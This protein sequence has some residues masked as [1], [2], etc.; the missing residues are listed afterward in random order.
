MKMMLLRRCRVPLLLAALGAC[1]PG[2]PPAAATPDAARPNVL[3]LLTDD[4]GY[5]EL[6]CH[7]NPVLRTPNLDRLHDESLRFTDFHAAPMCTPT[8]GQLMTGLD[9]LRNGAMNVS[10][11][12]T[13]LRRD[14]PTLPRLFAD[15]GYR[16]GLFGKWHLGDAHPYRPEDRG[17]QE[18]L[19][20]P[21]SHIGSVPDA[22][23]NDYFDDTYIRNGRRERCEGY[24]T[25]V[26]FRE[27]IG[28]M[29]A[30]SAAGRP[31]LCYLATAAPHAPHYVPA[32]YREAMQRAFD[33]AKSR[34]PPVPPKTAAELVRYLAMIAHLDDNVGRLEAFLDEAGLRRNTIV[35][36][37]SDNGGAFG[38]DYF[39][40]GMKGRK[41]TLW[42]GGH[43]VPCFVRWP[44]GGLR[45]PSDIGGL[46]CVQD[47]LP[48]LLDLCGVAAPAGA[49]FDGI[50]L[51][52]ALRGAA[53]LPE[54]RML[55]VN[56]SRMPIGIVRPTPDN[57]AVPRRE[58]A[59]VLWKRWRLLED[60]ALYDLDTDPMQ[61]RNVIDAHPDV[62][63]RMRGRLDAWWDGVKDLCRE[64]QPSVIGSDAGNPVM[65]TACE[66]TDVFVDQQAQVRR[67]ERK[68]GVWQLDVASA[69]RYRFELRR[70]P[71]ESGLRLA[72]APAETRVTDGTLAAGTAWPVARARMKVGGSAQESNA[73]PDAVAVRFEADLPAGRTELQ[74]WLLGADGTEFGGAYYVRVERRGPG[75]PAGRP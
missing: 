45:A 19:W 8:R 33:A 54:D 11:G 14:L 70:F 23:E 16:T 62:A 53:A 17:F 18:T 24:T 10:S 71:P 63:A 25:D 37:L 41:T 68:N 59:A 6:S 55:V 64:I 72:D 48:T 57:P 30:Q 44:A 40:A 49:R 35:V 20:F 47:L 5:G 1:P 58:G 65:L 36:F 12:R 67:G 21:S 15:A 51:A 66:W 29:R 13:L 75:G 46:A 60:R 7:G 43:R 73:A 3:I 61:E 31:F 2:P 34:L 56:Y 52:P 32:A 26:F 9:A 28:W 4:Q 74:T 22:W 42:E 27:A 39:N 50:S 38:P 69:G